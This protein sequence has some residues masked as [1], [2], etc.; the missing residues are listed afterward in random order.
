MS[1]TPD[2]DLLSDVL[3]SLKLRV[4]LFKHGT[5]RGA[6]AL[7]SKGITRATLHFI[8]RGQVWVHRKGVR[9][10]LVLRGG[11]LVMF[12]RAD[13]HQLS[14]TPKRLPGM[15][16]GSDGEGA[17]STVLCA[18][19]ELEPGT[20][21]PVMSTLPPV[22]IVSS[23]DSAT[24]AQLHGIARVMLAEYDAG[25]PGRQGILDRL[26]EVLFVLVLRQH[27]RQAQA[28]T[29]FLAALRDER[30]ARSLAALH[31]EPGAPWRVEALAREA[32]MSRT[33]FAE[34][35]AQLLGQTPIQYLT[36]WRMQLAEDLLRED[37]R[38]VAQVADRLGYQTEAAFRRA[39]KRV[40]SVSPGAVRRSPRGS[41]EPAHD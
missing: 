21:N 32:G 13:W 18:M 30:I 15:R 38:S 6:W 39:F 23:E 40:R 4:S 16:L 24:S 29:G 17:P 31:R 20:V 36:A 7:D 22:L 37:R 41:R 35:F 28:L 8:G 5:Y 3:R 1:E 26:A 34:R 10:P 12:P 27:M 14:G 33:V 25:G 11:D 19:V 9:E 2:F